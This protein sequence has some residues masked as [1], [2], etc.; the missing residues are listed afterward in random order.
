MNRTFLAGLA[1][2]VLAASLLGSSIALASIPSTTNGSITSCVNKTTSGVRIIDY[3]GGK[4]CHSTER[5]LSWSSGPTAH[6]WATGYVPL[7][8]DKALHRVATLTVPAAGT[9]TL[10]ARLQVHLNLTYNSANPSPYAGGSVYA[11]CELRSPS[12]TGI[13][14]TDATTLTDV[15]GNGWFAFGV[16]GTETVSAKSRTASLWCRADDNSVS[17]TFV[18]A[19]VRMHVVAT[20]IAGIS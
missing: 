15:N 11:N 12:N 10:D 3:Q 17:P 4:R 13:D 9:W 18:S 16:N 7:T 2:A 19:S 1:G 8:A 20:R 14:Y 5:M 6:T